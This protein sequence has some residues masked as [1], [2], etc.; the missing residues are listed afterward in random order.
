MRN[1]SC[2]NCPKSSL[3]STLKRG[4]R[5][6]HECI[7]ELSV[8]VIFYSLQVSDRCWSTKHKSLHKAKIKPTYKKIRSSLS[9][10]IAAKSQRYHSSA[11]FGEIRSLSSFLS[12]NF[13]SLD[14]SFQRFVPETKYPIV[15][16][17]HVTRAPRVILSLETDTRLAFSVRRQEGK[18]QLQ[19]HLR[20]ARISLIV[21]VKRFVNQRA[22]VHATDLSPISLN[23]SDPLLYISAFLLEVKKSIVFF[24]SFVPFDVS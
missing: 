2:Q 10:K 11:G 17:P 24:L 20:H 9:W 13:A 19:G 5:T 18:L 21:G 4:A 6:R 23:L 1:R 8:L 15:A 16:S 22:T 3:T 14:I 7:G 12:C